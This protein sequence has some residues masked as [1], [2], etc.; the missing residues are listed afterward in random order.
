MAERRKG[1]RP[2]RRVRKQIPV[3]RAYIQSTFNNTIVT[4]TDPNGNVITWS[5]SGGAGFK[6]SRK[7][8]PYAAGVAAEK[9]AR[10][11]M[12]HGMRQVDVFVKG[13]GSGREA[14]I[15]S[16]QAAGLAVTA[17]TDVTPIPHNGCRPPKR[18]RV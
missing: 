18:R 9:A 11:A 13:P 4:I 14:A 6:G 16:L 1:A 5:S 15:R 8:T 7:S 17:I 2:R 3:G 10:Q 12:E